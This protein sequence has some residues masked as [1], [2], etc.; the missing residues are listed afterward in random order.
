MCSLEVSS[1]MG[2]C[3]ME[4]YTSAAGLCDDV[5]LLVIVNITYKQ[6]HNLQQSLLRRIIKK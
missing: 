5:N 6:T 4:V 3:E 2:G 1:K